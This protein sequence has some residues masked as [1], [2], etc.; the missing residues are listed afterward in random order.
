MREVGKKAKGY[1]SLSWYKLLLNNWERT[2][3]HLRDNSFLEASEECIGL[4]EV[5]RGYT[6]WITDIL[7][8]FL[9]SDCGF[10]SGRKQ[11]KEEFSFAYLSQPKNIAVQKLA[12][13]RSVAI[14]ATCHSSLFYLPTSACRI[15][16]LDVYG[17]HATPVFWCGGESCRFSAEIQRIEL[18]CDT[19]F[20][21]FNYL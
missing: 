2:I 1:G 18:F 12:Y 6:V 15:Q 17:V 19:A 21:I 13:S 10:F 9:E 7:E 14:I 11:N 20:L 5:L 4:W 8:L 16:W 3:K